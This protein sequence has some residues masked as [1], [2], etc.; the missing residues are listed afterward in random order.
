MEYSLN[1]NSWKDKNNY[2]HIYNNG[3][4]YIADIHQNGNTHSILLDR[5][6]AVNYRKGLIS[7]DKMLK[8]L[9]ND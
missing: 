2:P 6:T 4:K 7:I 9:P 1:I 8:M 3:L 5:K